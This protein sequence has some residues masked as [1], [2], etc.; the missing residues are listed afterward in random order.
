MFRFIATSS[1]LAVALC[2]ALARPSAAAEPLAFP[3]DGEAFPA[4][5][6]SIEPDWQFSFTSGE[7]NRTL[8]GQDLMAWGCPVESASGI[9]VLLIGGGQIFTSS[10]KLEAE[11]LVGASASLGRW[12]LPIEVCA[13][14]V[15]EGQSP[16]GSGNALRDRILVAKGR[17][18]RLLLENGDELTGT[19]TALSET[20]VTLRGDG[21]HL[22]IK[23]DNL[24]AIVFDPSLL[25]KSKPAGLRAI[26]GLND[27]S[28]VV[29]T[30]ITA[31]DRNAK[32]LV[33]G[34]GEL[35]TATIWITYLQMLGG[36]VTYL[37]DLEPASYRH[38]PL[39]SLTWP[40]HRDSNVHGVELR[41]A[42]RTYFK[43]LGM[44]SPSRITYDL[45]S[46]YKRFDAELALDDDTGPRGSVAFRVF[47]D[48]GSGDWQ[49][50]YASPILRGA[51][52]P[53][54]I[55]IAIDGAKRISLLVDFA[56]RGDE[57]DHADWL[58]ARVVK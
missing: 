44:H 17:G 11:S 25:A 53:L 46:P 15:L 9:K 36:R 32:L 27:G 40:Y 1:Y 42:G 24:A 31:D 26:V 39:L 47:V 2:I 13:G 23:L 19:I 35:Q 22:E 54:P 4:T 49:E 10:V 41:V 20:A 21:D 30:Q 18:D 3:I 12:S 34:Q 29:A 38:L 5:L 28:Y 16:R 33:A 43:G 14:I 56:D 57:L 6:K 58:N 50:R 52:P 8:A 45:D 48:D 51:Q 37:S 7:N 55:S